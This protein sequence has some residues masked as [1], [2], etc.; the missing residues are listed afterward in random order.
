MKNSF[1]ELPLHDVHQK[2]L[3]KCFRAFNFLTKV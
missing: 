2:F 1:K 3:Y